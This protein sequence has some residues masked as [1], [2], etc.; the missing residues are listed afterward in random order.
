MRFAVRFALLWLAAWCQVIAVVAMPLGPVVL[1]GEPLDGVPICHA[2]A[3]HGQQAPPRPSHTGHDCLLCT[4]CQTHTGSVA[5]LPPT[6][7]LPLRQSVAVHVPD[8]PRARAPP[9]RTPSAAQPRG[10]PALI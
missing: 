8:A 7:A 1:G 6:S 2:E 3:G 10:P 9:Y 5:L 4:V